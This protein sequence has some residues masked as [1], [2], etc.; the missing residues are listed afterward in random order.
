MNPLQTQ[1]DSSVR[2]LP[3]CT[4]LYSTVYKQAEPAALATRASSAK[5][6]GG[7]VPCRWHTEQSPLSGTSTVRWQRPS[8]LLS[9]LPSWKAE[10]E[11]FIS[12]E[13][14]LS[15]LALVPGKGNRPGKKNGRTR[16]EHKQ[17]KTR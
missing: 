4:V 11:A 1:W 2:T 3:K 16:E 9:F 5:Q 7:Q 13:F 8:F 6:G 10:T 12:S 14:L 15:G 17:R